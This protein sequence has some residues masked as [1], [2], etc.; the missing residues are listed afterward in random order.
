MGDKHRST[1]RVSYIGDKMVEHWDSTLSYHIW[2]EEGYIA[3]KKESDQY[4][5]SFWMVPVAY[6]DIN[7]KRLPK[8]F[9]IW[10]TKNQQ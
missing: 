3:E 2:Q 9:I 10:Q 1:V 6:L 7:K 5:E 8:N 4:N